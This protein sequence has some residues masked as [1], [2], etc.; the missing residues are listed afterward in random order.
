[1]IKLWRQNKT[2]IWGSFEIEWDLVFDNICLCLH[3]LT[4]PLSRRS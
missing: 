4:Q 2:L 3:T 1:M